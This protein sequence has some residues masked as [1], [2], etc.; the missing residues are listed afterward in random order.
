MIPKLERFL[1]SMG[2]IPD[3]R[4]KKL[5]G[6]YGEWLAERNFLSKNYKFIARNW[7]SIR[8][9]RKEIDLIFRKDEVLVFVEVR[10]RK[11][12][13]Q[14]NGFNSLNYKK[15][16]ALNR[17]VNAFLIENDSRI[18]YFRLDLAEVD[19]P[20]SKKEKPLF[21]HHENIAIFK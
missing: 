11:S 16:K 10:A 12:G 3:F 1:W 20:R 18:E 17:S 8:D 21:F 13:S 14:V 6:R 5:G 15:R 9:R 7:R 4:C 2:H 19:L